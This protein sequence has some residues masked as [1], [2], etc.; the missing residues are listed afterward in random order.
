MAQRSEPLS[1]LK[2]PCRECPFRRA[3]PAGWIGSHEHVQEIIDIAVRDGRFPCHTQ[4][5]ELIDEGSDFVDAALDADVC[6][7]SAQFLSN[8][9]KLS[10]DLDVVRTQRAAGRSPEVFT[11]AAEMVAHHHPP[12]ALLKKKRRRAG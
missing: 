6:V 8:Q 1:V 5:N 10:R 7:G 11:H 4:V 9:C 12:E 3:S 2:K